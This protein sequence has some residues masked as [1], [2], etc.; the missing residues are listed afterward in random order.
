MSIRITF[1]A[2]GYWYVDFKASNYGM[3]HS[4]S[5][6]ATLDGALRRAKEIGGGK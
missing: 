6:H 2:D 4:D 1:N 5:R 3:F